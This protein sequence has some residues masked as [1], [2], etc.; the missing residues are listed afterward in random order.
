M[1]WDIELII[2]G[3][4]VSKANSR[5]LIY[6]N[7][8]PMIIKSAKAL[9]YAKSLRAQVPQ[10]V[11]LLTGDLEMYCKCVYSSRRSDLDPSLI[12]D[13]LQGLVYLNDRQ[14]KKMLLEWQLDKTWPRAEVKI[15]KLPDDWHG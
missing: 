3:Q 9:A 13:G 1:D 15:R 11:P 4:P 8:R 10:Q 5:R 7:G 14:V 6:K 2:D 12:L